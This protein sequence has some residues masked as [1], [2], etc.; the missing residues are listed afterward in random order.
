[1][2]MPIV[3]L[4]FMTKS[5]SSDIEESSKSFNEYLFRF[6]IFLTLPTGDFTFGSGPSPCFVAGTLGNSSQ[7]ERIMAVFPT[8]ASPIN[9]NFMLEESVKESNV[10][11]CESLWLIRRKECLASWD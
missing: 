3:E 1:M 2:S 9:N 10:M 5:E 4:V 6:S 8:P 7:Y 11:P